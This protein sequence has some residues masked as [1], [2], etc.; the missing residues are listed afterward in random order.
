[1][2]LG[3]DLVLPKIPKFGKM[4]ISE[5]NLRA[6]IEASRSSPGVYALIRFIESTG[7]WRAEF[8]GLLLSDL[9]LT[10]EDPRLRRW[11]GRKVIRNGLF[12]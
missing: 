1:M 5:G 12:L 3:V 7:C 10:V 2:I 8:A 11:L 6:I 9:K 4:G